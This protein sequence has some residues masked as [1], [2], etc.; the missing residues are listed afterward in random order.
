MYEPEFSVC[1][2]ITNRP[3]FQ[4][5]QLYSTVQYSTVQYSTVQ[6]STVQYSTVQYSTVQ[7]SQLL[8]TTNPVRPQIRKTETTI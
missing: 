2:N 8:L 4:L 1:V 3:L 5:S 6:Y 7:L